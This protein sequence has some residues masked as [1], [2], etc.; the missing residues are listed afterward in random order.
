MK[1]LFVNP[2]VQNSY[3]FSFIPHGLLEVISILRHQGHEILLMDLMNHGKN[4]FSKKDLN[5][6]RQNSFD[7]ILLGGYIHQLYSIKQL[8]RTIREIKRDAFIVTGGIGYHG[9]FR[10]A[11]EYTSCDLLVCCEMQPV[12]EDICRFIRSRKTND[13]PGGV[14]YK[15][16]KGAVHGDSLQEK[17]TDLDSLPLPYY[18]LFDADNIFRKSF[19]GFNREI[20]VDMYTS[21]GCPFRCN[22]CV[23]SHPDFGNRSRYRFKK[24]G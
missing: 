18:G 12:A 1:F 22:Y 16:E 9:I 20:S 15:D 6:I 21:R 13:L 14:L 23:N 2:P 4:Q 3:S 11:M 17:I 7:A 24:T 8:I 10:E 5:F 19:S